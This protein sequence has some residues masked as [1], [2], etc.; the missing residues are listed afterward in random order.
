MRR[1]FITQSLKRNI[2]SAYVME[3]SGHTDHKSFQ[4]Y[5]N[6]SDNEKD[7]MEQMKKAYK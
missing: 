1:T 2:G 4:R 7:L 6:M 3:M 5:I